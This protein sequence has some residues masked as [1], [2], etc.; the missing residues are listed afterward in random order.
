MSYSVSEAPEIGQGGSE[1]PTRYPLELLP[2]FFTE[3]AGC[4]AASAP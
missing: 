4:V 3:K 2:A 1:R